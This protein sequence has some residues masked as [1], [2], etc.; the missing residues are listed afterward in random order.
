MLCLLNKDEGPELSLLKGI[1]SFPCPAYISGF[2]HPYLGERVALLQTVY[3]HYK[4]YKVLLKGRGL[5]PNFLA[6]SAGSPALYL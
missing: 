4:D 1:L 5:K 2:P 3:Y 6:K